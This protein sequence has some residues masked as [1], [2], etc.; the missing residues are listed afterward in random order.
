MLYFSH[1]SMDLSQT[2]TLYV[3]IH[4]TYTANCIK[5]TD[6]VLQIQQFKL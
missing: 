4:T 6:I 2:Q 3:S 1:D 5:I